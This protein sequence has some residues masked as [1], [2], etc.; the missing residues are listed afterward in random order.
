MFRVPLINLF[1]FIV[2]PFRQPFAVLMFVVSDFCCSY[3]CP[4]CFLFRHLLFRRLSFRGLLFRRFVGVPFFTINFNIS[5]LVNFI[6][7]LLPSHEELQLCLVR[8]PGPQLEKGSVQP[9][10]AD[11]LLEMF[12]R[13]SLY[14]EL[15]VT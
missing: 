3:L 9:Y 7:E 4:N 10:P 5:Y 13:I 14:A 8:V 6:Q 12:W 15:Y 11:A 1:V 2:L